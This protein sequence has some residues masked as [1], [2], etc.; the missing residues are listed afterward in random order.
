[1]P[2]LPATA[3]LAPARDLLLRSGGPSR[4]Q[5]LVALLALGGVAR[6]EGPASAPGGSCL[7]VPFA[8]Q[9]D[10]DA[11]TALARAAPQTLLARIAALG[12]DV[13]RVPSARA[14]RPANPL[15][16]GLPVAGEPLLRQAEFQDSYQGRSIPAGADCCGLA[17]ATVLI[18]DTASAYTL[19]HEV[20]HLLIVPADGVVLRADLELRF[21]VAHHRL[22]LYQRRLYD[23]PWRLLQPLWRRDIAEAQRE[24][25]ALLFDRLRIGQSQEAIVEQMLAGC[26]DERSPYF[27]PRRRAE[28]R[29]YGEAMIDNAID[30]FNAVQGSVAFCDETVSNLRAELQAGRLDLP[31]GGSLTPAE[32]Q[33]FAAT[34]REVRET[35]ERARAEIEALKRFYSR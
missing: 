34:L 10:V 19:L 27:D 31:A 29:R 11:V 32:Q 20:V 30:L 4:R 5:A 33:A 24:V 3:C 28:G 21:A 13:L 23:D 1:M 22:S 35:L 12:I 26:I 18:R 17:R 15:L 6:A 7:R 14:D 2:S 16:A 9:I 25:A 8:Q